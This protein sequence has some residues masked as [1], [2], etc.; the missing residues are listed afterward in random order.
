MIGNMFMKIF[1]S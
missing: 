1:C